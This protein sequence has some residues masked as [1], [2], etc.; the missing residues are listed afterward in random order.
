MKEILYI[1][2]CLYF[3]SCSTRKASDF[4]SKEDLQGQTLISQAHIRRLKAQASDSTLEQKALIFEKNITPHLHKNF[5]FTPKSYQNNKPSI[6]RI[7]MTALF[8]SALAFKY[9]VLHKNQDRKL[10]EELI[11]SIYAADTANG[12]DGFIPY[13]VRIEEDQIKITSNETHEN[14]YAQLFFAYFNILN[15]VDHTRIHQKIRRHV[16]LIMNHFHTNN[17]VLVDHEGKKTEFSDLSPKRFSLLHNRQLSL[18]SMI[19]FALFALDKNDDRQ[20]IDKIST[21]RKQITSMNY[22]EK[23]Q[24]LRWQIGA[25]EFPTQSSSWLN[26]LK[27]YTGFH[28]SKKAFY[29]DS[30]DKLH[31]AYKQEENVFFQL[32]DLSIQD[33]KD[34]NLLMTVREQLKTFPTD[35]SKREVI[36]SEDTGLRFQYGKYIKLKRQLEVNSPMPI[37]RRPLNSYEWKRNQLRV[38]GNFHG[39]GEIKFTGIDYLQAYWLLRVLEKRASH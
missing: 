5:K 24:S 20:L 23:S 15:S 30:I 39:G 6:L 10:I 3:F 35:L 1:I 17:F 14:V 22:E 8:M 4:Y 38:D 32:I 26:F 9:E 12:L 34:P 33:Q 28:S 25:L 36:N 29:R 2:L 31:K 21:T 18:I 27:I 7:D 13:K 11:D 19:D 16:R 37:Y